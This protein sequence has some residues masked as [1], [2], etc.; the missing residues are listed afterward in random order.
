M[1]RGA[2]P[3]VVEAVVDDEGNTVI[4]AGQFRERLPSG[5][6]VRVHVELVAPTRRPVE[7]LLPDLPELSWEKFLAAS[8]LVIEDAEAG[9]RTG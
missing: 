8:R 3:V 7:G 6:R 9:R 2:D 1:E 4:A 5:T